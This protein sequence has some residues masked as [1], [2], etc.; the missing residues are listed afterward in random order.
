MY[1]C[2]SEENTGFS[3]YFLLLHSLFSSIS[4]IKVEDKFVEQKLFK[5]V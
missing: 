1:Q 4:L 3:L 2:T 5:E